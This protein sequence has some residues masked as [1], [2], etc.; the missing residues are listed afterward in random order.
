MKVRSALS[1]VAML[2]LFSACAPTLHRPSTTESATLLAE[3]HGF[4]RALKAQD[5]GALDK[6]LWPDVFNGKE[7]SAI[8][9][10]G[11]R[12]EPDALA[13]TH[14]CYLFLLFDSIGIK[15]EIKHLRPQLSL[16]AFYGGYKWAETDPRMLEAP[17]DTRIAVVAPVV[18]G[19]PARYPNRSVATLWR[20][21]GEINKPKWQV[22]GFTLVKHS[23]MIR[24]GCEYEP[25]R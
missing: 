15:R 23:G 11:Y 10:S 1:I 9:L 8:I 12:A 6:Y 19:K 18:L 14:F 25:V 13:A 16:A 5:A 3:V 24:A 20:S 4:Q 2:F 21:I 7:Y 22:F 17:S